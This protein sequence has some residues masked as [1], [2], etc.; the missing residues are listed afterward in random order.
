M[1]VDYRNLQEEMKLLSPPHPG[2]RGHRR[3]ASNVSNISIESEMSVS[4]NVSGDDV[5]TQAT[6]STN[7]AA[8]T[9][10]EVGNILRCNSAISWI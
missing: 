1:T 2:V 7:G 8:D 5:T 6:T 3:T 10:S 4:T 9:F